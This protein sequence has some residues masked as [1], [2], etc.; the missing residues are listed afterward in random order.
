[1]PNECRYLPAQNGNE[2]APLLIWLQGGP[3]GSSLFGMFCEMGP[4]NVDAKF[5]LYPNEFTWNDK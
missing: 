2:S 5:H 3:G 1:M 4:F